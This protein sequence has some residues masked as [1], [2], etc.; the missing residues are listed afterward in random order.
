MATSRRPASKGRGARVTRQQK[1]EY[2]A[3]R[4]SGMNISQS[5][6]SANFSLATAHRIEKAERPEHIGAIMEALEEIKSPEAPRPKQIGNLA[7]ADKRALTTFAYFQRRFFGRIAIGWQVEAAEKMVELL[8]TPT[9]EYVVVN[10]P[11]G[12]GKSTLFTLDFAAWATVRNRTIRGQIGSLTKRQASWYVGRLRRALERTIPQKAN[13]NDLKLGLAMDAESTLA[14]AYGRFEPLDRDRWSQDEFIVQQMGSVSIS[15]KEPTWSAFGKDSAFLGGRYDLVIWDD[16]TDPSKI[17][18]ATQRDDL[19]MW[20]GDI[21]ESRLEPGGLMVLQGQRTGADDIY[22]Y[23][24]DMESVDFDETGEEIE[25]SGAKKYHHVLFRAHYET[26][27]DPNLHK[28]SSPPYPEGCL[29]YP[30]RLT[31]KKLRELQENRSERFRVLYQ[32]EDTD[33]AEL[34]V[35]PTWIWGTN[36][37]PG[38]IDRTRGLREFPDG[39]G[40]CV[41]VVTCDPSPTNRWGVLWWLVQPESQ[42]RYLIDIF[43]GKMEAPEL[44]DYNRATQSYTGLMPKWQQ[45]SIELGIPITHWV[46]E[47]NAAQRFMLQYEHTRLW[48]QRSNVQIISHTTGRNKSDPELGVETIA[49]HFRFGRY[50]L[51]YRA[52][53][54]HFV[55]PLIME[56]TRYGHMRTDDLVMATWFLDWN[57]PRIRPIRKHFRPA[58]RPSWLL[59]ESVR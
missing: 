18:S 22:R 33:P 15:E 1:I 53:A 23:A 2:W 4:E 12:S 25:G 43:N 19:K 51:P 45:T 26:R 24:L 32:Q 30:R 28:L 42:V 50:R 16:L 54:A 59:A 5:A 37:H 52:D 9:E 21:A 55:Q 31:W 34:L 38:C 40:P 56:L 13:A 35:Q 11:P 20:Y 6:K 58:Q 36:G 39:L 17:R 14:M 49:P 7:P 10:C 29:I 44:L 46:V 3:S 48:A 8:E 27:C 47:I 41:S 57:L